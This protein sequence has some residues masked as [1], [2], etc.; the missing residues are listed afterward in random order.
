MATALPPALPLELRR[1]AERLF[2]LT[3]WCLG[4]DVKHP[5]GNLLLRSGLTRERPP[6]GQQG[7]SVYTATLAGGGSLKLWGFGVLCEGGDAA[8]F[9]ARDGFTPRL[10]DVAS[11]EWPVFEAERLQAASAPLT[12]QEQRACRA[13]V[14]VLAEWLA[15]YEQWV[16][17]GVGLSW[18]SECFSERRKAPAVSPGQLAAAW[19]RI[20]ARVRACDFTMN[21]ELVAPSAG[22]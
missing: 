10:V 3:M 12:F 21:D 7:Q 17:D 22:A 2:D 18:R 8:V 13:S 19:W 1:D 15:R 16:A 4:R 11:M 6:E 20:S 9:I 5:E 14:A